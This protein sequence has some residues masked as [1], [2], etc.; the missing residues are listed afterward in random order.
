MALGAHHGV[1]RPIEPGLEHDVAGGAPGRHGG[2]V[3]SYVVAART[4]TALAVGAEILPGGLVLVFGGVV[5]LLLTADVAGETVLVP[6][7]H[8]DLAGLVGVGDVEVVEPL[9]AEHVPAWREHD[10]ASG[11]EGG[12]VMLNAAVAERVIHTVLF[13][14]AGEGGFGD[15]VDSVTLAQGVRRAAELEFA[16]GEIAFDAG[17][18]GGLHH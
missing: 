8:Q 10:Y 11:G 3:V 17:F 12:Q 9:L 4:V 2:A 13:G 16:E 14:F 7:L 1:A 6:D 15:V 18:V 5:A